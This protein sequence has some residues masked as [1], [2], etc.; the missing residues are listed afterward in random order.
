MNQE[1]MEAEQ[2]RLTFCVHMISTPERCGYC[3]D[4]AEAEYYKRNGNR[5]ESRA[6]REA[7]KAGWIAAIIIPDRVTPKGGIQ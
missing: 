4:D 1:E 5:G 7:W 2:A 3:D 6:F